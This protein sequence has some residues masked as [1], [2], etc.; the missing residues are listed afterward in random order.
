MR[1]STP[2]ASPQT[3]G[4]RP[5]ETETNVDIAQPHRSRI[6][7]K[8]ER[9]WKKLNHIRVK[10]A[11]LFFAILTGVSSCRGRSAS[12]RTIEIARCASWGGTP[13]KSG[14]IVRNEE[15]SVPSPCR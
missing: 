12:P 3:D 1:N 2:R 14:V 11:A 4:I 15:V 6:G 13:I 9:I 10:I 5:D 7:K 8:Y